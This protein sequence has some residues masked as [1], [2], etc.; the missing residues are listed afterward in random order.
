MDINRNF[1]I[2]YLA[3]YSVDGQT[4]YIDRDMPTSIF[5]GN[6]KVSLIEY[7][8]RIH[9][10][11]EKLFEEIGEPY[12]D[13]HKIATKCEEKVV[14]AM[15]IDPKEYEKAL[16]PYIYMCEHKHNVHLPPDLDPEPYLDD[17]KFDHWFKSHER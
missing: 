5:V 8:L 14:K 13:S 1:D 17:P 7:Y 9:E 2:P 15:G 6:K 12:K 4:I 10:E 16:K 11:I 3:G